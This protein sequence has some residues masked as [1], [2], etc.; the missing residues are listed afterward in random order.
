MVK[1]VKDLGMDTCMTLGMLSDQQTEQLKE[2]GL[3]YYNHNI[4]TSREYYDK[5]VSTRTFD[6]RLATLTAAATMALNCAQA[7]SSAWA[8]RAQTARP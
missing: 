1:S 6:D 7:G 2:A 5:V 4:D 3:D 8:R